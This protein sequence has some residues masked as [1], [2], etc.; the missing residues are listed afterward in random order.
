MSP[1]SVITAETS[2]HIAFV[3]FT[4]YVKDILLKIASD[5]YSYNQCGEQNVG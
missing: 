4:I 1:L 5:A 3:N 2:N